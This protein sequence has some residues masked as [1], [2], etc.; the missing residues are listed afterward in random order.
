LSDRTPAPK[1]PTI[2]D[3]ARGAEVSVATVSNVLRGTGRF[4]EATRS[5]VESTIAELGFVPNRLASE[6]R[7]QSVT[8]IGLVVPKLQDEFFSELAA[9]V[10]D[11]AAQRDQ[12]VVVGNSDDSIE[13]ETSILDSFAEQRIRGAIVVPISDR[14]NVFAA[15]VAQVWVGVERP[16]T[17]SVVVDE[18]EGGR[19]A[20]VLLAA[21]GCR[22]IA[23]LGTSSRP[24]SARRR[25]V[26][27]GFGAPVPFIEL[28]N[29]SVDSGGTAVA[30]LTKRIDGVACET[31]LVA[32]GVVR[33]ALRLGWA[34]PEDL[35]VVGHDDLRRSRDHLIPLTTVAQPTTA[36]GRASLEL[37]NEALEGRRPRSIRLH[38]RLVR[39]ASA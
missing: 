37:L 23:Y 9:A 17:S 28:E 32:V 2:V 14:S 35:A 25:G 38:P 20:G 12:L 24:G 8:T 31:D 39:R 5:L 30:R 18:E 10:V 26:E 19:L 15:S 33:E 3:V 21:R 34:V 36:I 11:A 1:R 27:L 16:N 13:R 29:S 7:R 22:S 4:S 6:L